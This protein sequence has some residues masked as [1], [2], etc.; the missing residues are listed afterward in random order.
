MLFYI[1]IKVII[2][3]FVISLANVG[4][5][6]LFFCNEREVKQE[7]FILFDI[8]RKGNLMRCPYFMF[9]SC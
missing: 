7:K 9:Y 5:L 8:K 4:L 2:F 6:S 1:N 3:G